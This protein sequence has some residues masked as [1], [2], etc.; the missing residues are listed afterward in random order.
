MMYPLVD[1]LA[2]DGIPVAV[3]CR[4][5]GFSKQAYYAW[6]ARPVTDR[7]WDD[8]HLINAAIAIHH[9]DPE[10]GYRFIADELPARGI[11]AGRNRVHRLCTAARLFSAHSKKRGTARR[12]GPPVHDDLV[13]RD[14]T[15]PRPNQLWLTDITEHPTAEGKLYLCA[16]KDACTNRIVGYSIDSRMTS[17]LAVNALANAVALRR[18]TG[19]VVHSDRGSQFRS[20]TYVHALRTAGLTGSMGRVGA[21]ADNAAMESF[22]ALLQKNVLNRHRS[23]AT[24]Q[25]LRLA[26]VTW[27]EKTYHRRRRQDRLGRLTPVEY[28]TLLQAAHA[29]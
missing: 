26:I 21:C 23:W 18:P 1:D 13:E 19:T 15:A 11:V 22:F 25:D 5:L 29:A 9:D 12:P 24:R 4:V 2:A 10:F 7:D 14:F 3:T 20:H 8:A 6:R 27:I 16:I 17:Q 28:E